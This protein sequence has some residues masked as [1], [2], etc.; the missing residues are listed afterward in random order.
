MVGWFVEQEKV[1]PGEQDA[2]QFKAP[3]LATGKRAQIE[4]EAIGPQTQ[5]VDQFAYLGFGGVATIVLELLL[6]V[7]KAADIAFAGVLLDGDTQ[8]FEVD[9]C[10]GE[11]PT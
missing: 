2:G 11:T 4:F 10:I 6:S 3:T 7:G 9:R 5:P 8:L 1:A